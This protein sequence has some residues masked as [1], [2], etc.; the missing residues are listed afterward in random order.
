MKLLDLL[1]LSL[2]IVN[3]KKLSN[4]YWRIYYSKESIDNET[5]DIYTI[6]I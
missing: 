4:Q 1:E 2:N 6:S 3:I 5:N